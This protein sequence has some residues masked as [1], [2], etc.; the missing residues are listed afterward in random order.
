V[1]QE[2]GREGILPLSRFW[3]SNKPFDAPLAGLFEHWLVSVITMLAPPPG[4]AYNFILKLVTGYLGVVCQLLIVYPSIISYPLAV[5]NVFVGAGLAW[6]YLRRDQ[7]NW[8]APV[9]ATLPVAIFFTLSNIY[10]VVAPFVPPT[11][12]QNIYND[13]PYYLHCLVGIGL[14]VAGGVYW[15]FWARIIPKLRGYE[16]EAEVYVA[17]DGWTR[18][19]FVKKQL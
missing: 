16:L 7:Y 5:I 8:R 6:I 17:D 1:V 14:L 9:K 13:L 3:A 2:L 11:G 15:L 10:L 18:K 12:D 19:R 4:D